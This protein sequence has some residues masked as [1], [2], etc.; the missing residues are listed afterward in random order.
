MARTDP[1]EKSLATEGTQRPTQDGFLEWDE[2]TKLGVQTQLR[3]HSSERKGCWCLRIKDNL[4]FHL[5]FR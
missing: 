3:K 5:F 1:K 2:K 4:G